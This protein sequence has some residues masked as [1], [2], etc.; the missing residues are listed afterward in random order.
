MTPTTLSKAGDIVL[1]PFPYA[2]WPGEKKHPVVLVS[3]DHVMRDTGISSA[4][5]V[6]SHATRNARDV[7]I[8]A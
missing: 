7:P 3:V 8:L 4:A 6:T 2:D 1:T 5:M